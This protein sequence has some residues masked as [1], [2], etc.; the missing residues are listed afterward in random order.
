MIK[1]DYIVKVIKGLRD[2]KNKKWQEWLNDRK[3]VWRKHTTWKRKQNNAD[4]TQQEAGIPKKLIYKCIKFKTIFKFSL[5]TISLRKND[6]YCTLCTVQVG[7]TAIVNYNVKM[8][9][10]DY[11]LYCTVYIHTVPYIIRQQWATTVL[12]AAVC[13]GATFC[14]SWIHTSCVWVL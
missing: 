2:R 6:I 1:Q 9:L 5:F 4:L 12:H 13:Y 10:L 3:I 14:V 11:I 8:N 7:R